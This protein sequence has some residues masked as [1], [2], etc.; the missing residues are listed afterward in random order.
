MA[1]TTTKTKKI[2]VL[3]LNFCYQSGLYFIV[4]II[5]VL[6]AVYV[7]LVLSL[8][9][10]FAQLSIFCEIKQLSLLFIDYTLAIEFRV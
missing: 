2:S 5:A 8:H 1:H 10:R 9:D 3:T 4:I 6:V 7:S